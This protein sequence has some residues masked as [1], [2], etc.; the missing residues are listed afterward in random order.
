M[1]KKVRHFCISVIGSVLIYGMD[2]FELRC[3]M[4]N[5]SE[6]SDTKIKTQNLNIPY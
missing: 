4:L 6:S 1:V 2:G 3:S 5:T